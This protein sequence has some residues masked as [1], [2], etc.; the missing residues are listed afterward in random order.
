MLRETIK[1]YSL[2]EAGY[3]KRPLRGPLRI[4]FKILSLLKLVLKLQLIAI[5]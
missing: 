2:S 1:T 4:S 3:K 5:P